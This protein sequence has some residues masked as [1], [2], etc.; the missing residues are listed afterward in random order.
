M[1]WICC[2]FSYLCWFCSQP[3][4]ITDCFYLCTSLYLHWI[5]SYSVRDFLS[6]FHL[7]TCERSLFLII[8]VPEQ[9]LACSFIVQWGI[10][11]L[12]LKFLFCLKILITALWTLNLFCFSGLSCSWPGQFSWLILSGLWICVHLPLSGFKLFKIHLVEYTC[13]GE[14]T[15]GDVFTLGYSLTRNPSLHSPACVTIPSKWPIFFPQTSC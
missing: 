8:Q 11:S 4:S 9:P 12:A 6:S 14:L 15:L 1:S 13:F 5:F 3:F 2:F 7:T 10:M